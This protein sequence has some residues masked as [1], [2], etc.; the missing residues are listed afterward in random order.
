MF[1][2]KIKC[3]I[4]T[5]IYRAWHLTVVCQDPCDNRH[6]IYR[7]RQTRNK[8]KLH[9]SLLFAC[10]HVCM[11]GRLAG[12]CLHVCMLVCLVRLGMHV[13]MLGEVERYMFACWHVG[14]FLCWEDAWLHVV[15]HWEGACLRLL[16][17]LQRQLVAWGK[18]G[19]LLAAG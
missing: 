1:N 8:I 18:G 17:G 7:V 6:L 4:A 10:L 9:V 14:M 13:C 12:A 5:W 11:L 2:M 19:E 16:D 3:L 15:G